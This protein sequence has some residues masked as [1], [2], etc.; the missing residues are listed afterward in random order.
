MSFFH[1]LAS[2]S[3]GG[4]LTTVI[5]GATQD[6]FNRYVDVNFDPSVEG[7]GGGPLELADLDLV[8]TQNI[9]GVAT[10]A[11]ITSITK[12]DGSPL[13]GGEDIVRMNLS[14]TG[15]PSGVETIEIKP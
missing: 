2:I 7:V 9:G 4:E 13:T 1:A 15:N 14:I 11:S 12:V 5:S 3:D 6:V 8:F 10:N